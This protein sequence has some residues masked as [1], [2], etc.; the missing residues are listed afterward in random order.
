MGDSFWLDSKRQSWRFN[1]KLGDL[2]GASTP[3]QLYFML[4]GLKL[5]HLLGNF[6]V[7]VLLVGC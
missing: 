5:K 7:G 4:V 1:C 2:Q 3:V 6:K